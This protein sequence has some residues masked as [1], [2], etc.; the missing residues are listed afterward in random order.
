M[1]MN[2]RIAILALACASIAT[3]G[4]AQSDEVAETE[5]VSGT[6]GMNTTF[7]STGLITVPTAYTAR[8]RE[9]R[10]GGNWG[11]NV[12]GPSV[13]YGLF[14]YVE[15][16][17]SYVDRDGASNKVLA[18]GKVTLTPGNFDFL[19]VG[20][21]TIDPFD[22]INQT[23]YVVG[24]VDLTPP[25]LKER[26]GRDALAFRVHAGV[27]TG[28]FRERLIGGA[29]LIFA[30]KFAVVAEYDALDVNAALRYKASN[31][32]QIQTGLRNKGLFFGLTTSL[33]F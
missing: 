11:K 30:D 1:K 29:E 18:T 14:R 10:V 26:V 21:G 27:G 20:I 22:A 4:W 31:D 17:A 13:N 9:F 8:E 32:V 12:H 25:N 2:Y 19:T 16:G 6:T 5:S 33:R 28:L 23:F 24:T 15:V 7:G 3:A